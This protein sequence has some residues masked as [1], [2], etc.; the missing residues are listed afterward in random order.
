M[1][2]SL[3]GPVKSWRSLNFTSMLQQ[4]I[5]NNSPS[6]IFTQSNKESG[7]VP[8]RK[9]NYALRHINKLNFIQKVTDYIFLFNKC[10]STRNTFTLQCLLS[11]FVLTRNK[12]LY[13]LQNINYKFHNIFLYLWEHNQE[14][15]QDSICYCLSENDIK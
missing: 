9:T 3:F 11:S 8:R 5:A 1:S 10:T 2:L 14:G 15:N 13:T 4:F 7:Y 6:D 12:Y